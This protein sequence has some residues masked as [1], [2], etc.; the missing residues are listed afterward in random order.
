LYAF[1]DLQSSDLA[2]IHNQRQAG[3]MR[4]EELFSDLE[5]QLEQQE[6]ADLAAEV[7][8]RTRREAGALRLCDRLAPARGTQV[9]LTVSGAGTVSGGL[10]ETGA[11]WLLLEE[12]G[13]AELL[14]AAD[15]VLS[16]A[17]LSTGSEVQAGEVW[18]RLDLR[19]AL[20][21]LARSRSNVH[22]VLRDGSPWSGTL[23]RVGA[24]H[25]ELAEHAAGEQRR[26]GAVR[27]AV[28]LPITGLAAV[29][30]QP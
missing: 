14:V 4:W 2:K 28:L 13:R 23:D 29:R 7:S 21:G 8:D 19:W 24:D 22:I 27:Q 12:Q 16:V 15:A 3:V 20:R 10:A 26:P 30:S 25:V 6:A 17:G 11:D 18:R 5:A 9:R 1:D